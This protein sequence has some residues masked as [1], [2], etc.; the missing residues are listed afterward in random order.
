MM[1]LMPPCDFL[2][3]ALHICS[4]GI[5]RNRLRDLFNPS[6]IYPGLKVDREKLENIR[7]C[8]FGVTNYTYS[9]SLILSLEDIPTCK[10]AEIDELAFVAFPL[11]AA[12]DSI[13]CPVSAAGLLGYWL[14]IRVISKK[15][16]LTTTVIEMIQHVAQ[17]TR[18]VWLLTAEKVFTMKCHWFF[19]H[20]MDIEL[21][22][23]GSLYQWTSAPF[24]SHHRRLQLK[25]N[26]TATN[27]ASLILEKYL[28]TKKIRNL[29]YNCSENN[30]SPLFES[31]KEKIENKHTKRQFLIFPLE[32]RVN[33]HCY[34]PK[35]SRID[36]KDL[37]EPERTRISR[38]S[39]EP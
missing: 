14:T 11:A 8:L 1:K 23:Q 21:L 17:Q 18:D 27:S 7:Q 4:E 16:D 13:T 5:T 28:L 39:D 30:E 25:M 6:S 38:S 20:A 24:E 22:H 3:G 32:V 34:I 37:Q 19:D 36:L 15:R 10:A 29:F 9:S 2:G 12:V 35:N 31:F 26:Q 33:E